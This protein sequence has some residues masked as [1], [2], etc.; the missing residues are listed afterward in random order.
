MCRVGDLAR[1]APVL[2]IGLSSSEESKVVS[3]S[4]TDLHRVC[5]NSEPK[6]QLEE[7]YKTY[8]FPNYTY[9]L[10]VFALQ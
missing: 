5:G 7:L 9:R 2:P 10:Y 4:C 6:H 3:E 1:L 8:F